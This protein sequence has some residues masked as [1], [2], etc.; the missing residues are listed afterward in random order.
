MHGSDSDETARIE[1]KFFFPKF[2]PHNFLK[3]ISPEIPENNSEVDFDHA[4][5]VHSF[6]LD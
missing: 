5:F 6:N 2:D 1:M 3:K 4:R